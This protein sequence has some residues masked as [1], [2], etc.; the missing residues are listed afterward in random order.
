MVNGRGTASLEENGNIAEEVMADLVDENSHPTYE[1]DGLSL[2]YSVVGDGQPI[3][4][5][6]GATATG[7]FEWGR[8]ATRLSSDYQCVLPDLRGHGRSEF[9][10]ST[11]MGQVICADLGHLIE[12]L[13]LHQPPHRGVFFTAPRSRSCSNWQREEPHDL[14]YW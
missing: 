2:A 14:S 12:H 10:E 1:R 8:L 13:V 7:E 6:H 9:R 5:V 11:E 4:R 3:L